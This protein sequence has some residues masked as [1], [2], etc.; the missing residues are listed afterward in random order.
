MFGQ[1]PD[2]DDRSTHRSFAGQ[3]D[4]VAWLRERS[5]GVAKRWA[6]GLLGDGGSWE[7]DAAA[8]LRP[9]CRGLVSFLPG[10]LT[11]ARTELVPLWS[12]CAGLYGSVAA[13]RGLSAG[14]VIDEFHQLREVILRMMFERPPVGAGGR[15]PF[16]E[17]LL[18][19]RALDIGVTQ[20]SV[21]HTDLLFFSLLH[22][23]GGPLPLGRGELEEVCEQIRALQLEHHRILRHMDRVRPK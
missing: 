6:E 15:L 16:R 17:V 20:A 4:L 12:E 8:V 23:T 13:R 3:V 22:G 10:L 1:T 11:P 5:P 18:L 9:F 2:S 21:G 19:N 7:G 14:E